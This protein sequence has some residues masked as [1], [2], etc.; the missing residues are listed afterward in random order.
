[1]DI[2]LRISIIF[3]AKAVASFT[4]IGVVYCLDRGINHL[5]IKHKKRESSFHRVD[6]SL[7]LVNTQLVH[8]VYE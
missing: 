8:R 3:L 2:F 4:I 1:M 6:N 5:Q 7:K